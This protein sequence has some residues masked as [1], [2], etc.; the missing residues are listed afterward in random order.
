MKIKT[1]Q[2]LSILFCISAACILIEQTGFADNSV[3]R[4]A[5]KYIPL[6]CSFFGIITDLHNKHNLKNIIIVSVFSFILLISIFIFNTSSEIIYI[7]IFMYLCRNVNSDLIFQKYCLAS[8]IVLIST[9]VSCWIGILPSI[10][11]GE[12][13]YLGFLYTTFG[14]NIF[15]SFLLS[16]V[17]HRK[18]KIKT[19]EWLIFLA[20]NQYFLI[21]TDTTSVYFCILLIMILFYI[22]KKTALINNNL[23]NKSKN[24]IRLIPFIIVLFTFSLQFY[25]NKN[26]SNNFCQQLN[27]IVNTRLSLNRIAMEKYEIR[28]LGQPIQWN[29]STT[30]NLTNLDYF[31]VD[32]SYIQIALQYGLL[33]LILLCFIFSK[34][35]EMSIL[36]RDSYLYISLLVFLLHCVFDPQLLSFRYDPFLII[37][38]FSIEY[39]H[40]NKKL[41]VIKN[42]KNS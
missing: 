15:L 21:M 34:A 9:I 13:H 4:T 40:K 25:Y 7:V 17:A 28:L 19:I 14:P 41:G 20:I 26:Y 6:L 35:F 31:Y 29:T 32:S 3:I 38:L 42:E 37:F 12:R 30:N 36:K 1:T 22:N 39:C 8:G 18:E 23:S 10:S 27:K 2:L 16:F 24:V 11:N 5:A 33:M